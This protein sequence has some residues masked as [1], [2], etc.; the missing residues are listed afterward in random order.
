MIAMQEY[1]CMLS[2]HHGSNCFVLVVDNAAT[3]QKQQG[4]K[5]KNK[6]SRRRSSCGYSSSDEKQDLKFSVVSPEDDKCPSRPRR[7][8]DVDYEAVCLLA[9]SETV[10]IAAAAV[11]APKNDHAQ[12]IW[13]LNPSHFQ[14][15]RN[16]ATRNET[17][18]KDD[19][20]NS[21]L[22]SREARWKF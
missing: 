20:P 19:T 4:K 17:S 6:Y 2:E 15:S 8:L 10:V 14:Y 9:N 16:I 21:D 7:T 12:N 18:V 22:I 13:S 1:F 11:A 5:E 3:P